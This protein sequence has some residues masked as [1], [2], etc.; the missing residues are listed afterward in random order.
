M[1]CVAST[2]A[3]ARAARAQPSTDRLPQ[4]SPGRRIEVSAGGELW[5]Q[6]F[7]YRS[8][9]K[10]ESVVAALAAVRWQ[11]ESALGVRA[12]AWGIRN[13]REASYGQSGPTIV[14]THT[15]LGVGA[16]A[17]AFLS[18]GGRVSLAPS[19]GLG[20]APWVR[21]TS[22]TSGTSGGTNTSTG[23]G[24]FWMLGLALR[25][26]PVVVEQHVVALGGSRL[27]DPPKPKYLPFTVGWRF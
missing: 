18:L 25:V 13:H 27:A 17:D 23:R 11:T 9:G 16:A 15:I 6:L 3:A 8:E 5:P 4:G 2:T 22:G 1:L 10:D 19:I 7:G 12:L 24:I 14:S 20:V 21:G 26:G